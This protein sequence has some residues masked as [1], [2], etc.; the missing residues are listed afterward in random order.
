MTDRAGFPRAVRRGTELH[1][2]GPNLNSGWLLFGGLAAWAVGMNAIGIRSRR[3][4]LWMGILGIVSGVLLF[5]AVLAN[6]LVPNNIIN[7]LS[8]GLGAVVLYPAWQVWMGI[9]MLK[10]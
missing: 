1:Q 7:N 2:Q 6:T 5:A 8:A 4:P 10:K 9:R 3:W